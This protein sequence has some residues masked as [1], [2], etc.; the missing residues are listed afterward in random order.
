MMDSRGDKGSGN[1][2]GFI[3]G[4]LVG[5]G[6][7]LLLA[8]ASGQDTRRR[9]GQSMKGMGDKARDLASNAGHELRDGARE[10]KTQLEGAKDRMTQALPY[11]GSHPAART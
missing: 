5:A 9:L 10:V 3:L 1:M 11:D 7:A 6:V 2:T 4:S 8:P